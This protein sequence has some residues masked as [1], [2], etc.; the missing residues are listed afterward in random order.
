MLSLNQLSPAL[1]HT[2]RFPG[3]P[4]APRCVCACACSCEGAARPS[5][6]S[7]PCR[8]PVPEGFP[9]ARCVRWL[10]VCSSC[11]TKT[12]PA[13]LKRSLVRGC[14]WR[15]RNR[16]RVQ[17]FQL[18][19]AALQEPGGGG[20]LL[21][22]WASAAVVPGTSPQRTLPGSGGRRPPLR[23]RHAGP[24]P[25]AQPTALSWLKPFWPL[26]RVLA[27][28]LHSFS[29]QVTGPGHILERDV[30][31]FLWTVCGGAA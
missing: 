18:G 3:G 2:E 17:E 1:H 14:M 6:L 5:A 12:T 4:C 26:T 25:A 22:L 16:T 23:H 11:G 19:W 21:A 30:V 7:Q 24:S 13:G 20:R 9:L 8:V 27:F 10:S 15:D 31:W 28:L 29:L